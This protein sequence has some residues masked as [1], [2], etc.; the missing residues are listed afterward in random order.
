MAIKSVKVLNVMAFQ[1]L[2]CKNNGTCRVPDAKAG[3]SFC[4]AFQLQLCDGINILIGEN[5]VGKTT[6]L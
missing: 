2:W 5:G 1:R 3:D 4:E 6:L